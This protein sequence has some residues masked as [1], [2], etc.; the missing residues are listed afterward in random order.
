LRLAKERLGD[1]C[2]L[3]KSDA[4]ALPFENESFDAIVATLIH[5]DVEDLSA[6]WLEA[7]R[8]LRPAGRLVYVGT[9]PCFVSPFARFRGPDPPE[10]YPGYG[11]S[12]GT[13]AGPGI[14]DGIRRRVGV[15]H[16]P[17]SAYLNTLL[18]A[19]FTLERVVEA[20]E[21]E[22]PRR[23]GFAAAE[24][25]LGGASVRRLGRN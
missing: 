7:A 6:V 5:T 1:R 12:A 16:V 15:R 24:P 4:A 9:H 20:G 13:Y 14:G 25:N 8:V 21:E 11:I 2:T 10:L 18:D 23:F 3:V 17:L 19:G 22:Y